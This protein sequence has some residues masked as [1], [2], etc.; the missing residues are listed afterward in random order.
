MRHDGAEATRWARKDL[1]LRR[2]PSTQAALAWALYREGRL[3]DA[4]DMTTAALSW[5]VQDAQLLAQAAAVYL[6]AGQVDKGDQ[7]LRRAAEVHPRHQH[8]R[9]HR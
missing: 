8:F 5:S 4:L 9:A 2:G 6:A 7:L 3:A 1:R